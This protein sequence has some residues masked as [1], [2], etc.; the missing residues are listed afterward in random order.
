MQQMVPVWFPNSVGRQTRQQT[1]TWFIN[2]I[3]PAQKTRWRR[4]EKLNRVDEVLK[5]L[6]YVKSRMCTMFSVETLTAQLKQYQMP[7]RSSARQR[8][9]QGRPVQVA[10]C[11]NSMATQAS[12]CRRTVPH[13]KLHDRTQ[14]S[15]LRN[16]TRQRFLCV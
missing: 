9:G 5:Q 13:V 14:W 8:T 7:G 16:S 11:D 2:M 1:E 4:A 6:V 12:A 15:W 10:P 3:V